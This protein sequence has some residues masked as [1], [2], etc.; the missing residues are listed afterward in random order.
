MGWSD[1]MSSV[2]GV[3]KDLMWNK[4]K[5]INLILLINIVAVGVVIIM[6]KLISH[7]DG[8]YP[9]GKMVFIAFIAFVLG[10][11]L[12]IRLNEQV[13]SSNRYVLIP[14]TSFKLYFSNL[15]TTC[16]IY[17]YFGIIESGILVASLFYYMNNEIYTHMTYNSIRVGLTIKNFIIVVLGIILI[18]TLSTLVHL[19]TDFIN[20]FLALKNQKIMS[21]ILNVLILGLT[22]AVIFFTFT[23][24][25]LIA[26]ADYTGVPNNVFREVFIFDTLGIFGAVTGSL[27]FLEHHSE[28]NR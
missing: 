27:Y 8:N 10:I 19:T 1:N 24:M 25:S 15:V 17:L 4:F 9:A 28:T 16:L 23:R 26:F 13:F 6:G 21:L 22:F 7:F 5:L 11:I 3:S 2:L 18:W 12:L 20:N 14:I